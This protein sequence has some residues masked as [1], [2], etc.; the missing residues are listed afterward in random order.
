MSRQFPRNYIGNP[1]KSPF[2]DWTE[3]YRED[4]RERLVGLARHLS[5]LAP[6]ERVALVQRMAKRHKWGGPFIEALYR[7]AERLSQQPKGGT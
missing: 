3:R 7:E 1:E 2:P 4:E 6:A 5:G